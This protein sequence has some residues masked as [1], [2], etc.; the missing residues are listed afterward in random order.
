MPGRWY[1]TQVIK[2]HKPFSLG[3]RVKARK[4]DGGFVEIMNKEESRNFICNKAYAQKYFKI[5]ST[6]PIKENKEEDKNIYQYKLFSE[7]EING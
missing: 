5:T 2:S 6:K 1:E 3:E 7:E 4:T